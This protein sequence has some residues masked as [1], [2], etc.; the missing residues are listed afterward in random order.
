MKAEFVRKL[1]T[2]GGGGWIEGF[3]KRVSS[4]GGPV[5][6]R[7]GH[8]RKGLLESAAGC[9]ATRRGCGRKTHRM[10]FARRC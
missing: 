2:P 10:V 9:A 7:L 5:E 1:N 3:F 6:V 8:S 4:S